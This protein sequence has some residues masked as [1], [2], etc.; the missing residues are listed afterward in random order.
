M[1]PFYLVLEGDETETET[2]TETMECWM[3]RGIAA[4]EGA[5]VVFGCVRDVLGW[6][7][8]MAW[9]IPTISAKR[10][11]DGTP[12]HIVVC[13]GSGKAGVLCLTDQGQTDIVPH[14]R[15]LRDCAT[16]SQRKY[17]YLCEEK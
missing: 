14:L 13:V 17:Y 15:M 11:G 10:G 5:I 3:S 8:R 4:R 1:K 7:G 12:C 16:T 2:E 9:T 6:R